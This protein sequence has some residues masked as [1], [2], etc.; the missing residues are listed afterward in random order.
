[1]LRLMA[2]HAASVFSTFCV[3]SLLLPVCLRAQS[4]AVEQVQEGETLAS[5]D[6]SS[7]V[8]LSDSVLAD[9]LANTSFG[10]FNFTSTSMEQA[11]QGGARLE[12]YNYISADYR[13]SRARRISLRPV[14]HW[15]TSGAN[16][17]GEKKDG[18]IRLGDAFLNYSATDLLDLPFDFDFKGQMRVYAPTSQASRD[19]GMMVRLRPW[20]TASRRLTR[21]LEFSV[22]FEPDYYLQSRTASVDS[23]GRIV[24]TRNFGY[25]SSVELQYRV[26]RRFGLGTSFGH[27]QSWSHASPE[28]YDPNVRGRDRLN[29]A[30]V[31][32]SAN[33]DVSGSA[34]IGSLFMVLGV[35][36]KRDVLRPREPLSLFRSSESQYYLLSSYRF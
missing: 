31:S 11:N 36:Q 5:S 7:T 20:L 25:E 19:S 26:S 9:L 14:F 4:S 30:F 3:L 27:D 17:R 29:E 8:R 6:G 22:N 10:F 12:A 24:G 28:N 13:L 18:E 34:S 1:M 15:A 21:N 33:F 35:S 16:F 32:E 23:T 2:S